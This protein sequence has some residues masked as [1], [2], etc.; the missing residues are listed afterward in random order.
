MVPVGT[1]TD[2][3]QLIITH[4]KEPSFAV[5]RQ[6]ERKIHRIRLVKQQ[7]YKLILHRCEAGKPIECKHRIF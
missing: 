7:L 4:V 3:S 5:L 6:C 1:F 2:S